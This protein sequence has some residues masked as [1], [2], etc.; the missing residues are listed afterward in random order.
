[1]STSHLSDGCI[2]C[3]II[4]GEIPSF[5]VVETELSFAFLDISP[6]SEGHTLVVPKYHAAKLD[7]VPDQYLSDILPLSKK[8]ALSTGYPD[9]NLLQNNGK[10]AFQHVPHVHFHIIPK[11][12]LEDGMVFREEDFVTRK[13]EWPK[14]K[15]AQVLEKMKASL[16]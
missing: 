15:L 8:I 10:N 2:F 16:A 9:Y 13:V 12:S 5:K 3:K 4:K 1:M 6:L 7:E 14:E 11:P